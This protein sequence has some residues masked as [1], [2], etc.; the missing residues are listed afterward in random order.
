MAVEIETPQNVR[1]PSSGSDNDCCSKSPNAG[2]GKT[3]P[4]NGEAQQTDEA[5]VEYRCPNP[6]LQTAIYAL[7]VRIHRPSMCPALF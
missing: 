2:R 7:R 3:H 1:Q 4:S 5:C 6:V